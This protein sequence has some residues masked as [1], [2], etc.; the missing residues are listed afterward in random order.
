MARRRRAALPGRARRASAVRPFGARQILHRNSESRHRRPLRRR[1]AIGLDFPGDDDSGLHQSV[2]TTCSLE[3][4]VNP[5]RDAPQILVLPPALVGGT[6]IIGLVL[7]YFVW[8]V[9]I[10]P[11]TPARVLGVIVFVASGLLA[12]FAHRAMDRVGTN[13]FPTQPTLAIGT[14][15]PYRFTRNPLYIA[16]IGVYIG[17]T[18]WV[19]SVVMLLLFLPMVVI[20]HWGI[21]LREEE[22]L[23]AKFPEAYGAYRAKVRRWI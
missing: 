20:L 21:V 10:L 17:T 6:M 16:A 18:L 5:S 13:V 8:N 1:S 11:T 7:H 23:T 19:D 3:A 15:C 14:D 12:H 22:Y 4:D 2:P 9:E